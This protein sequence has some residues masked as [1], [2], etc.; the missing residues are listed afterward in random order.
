MTTSLTPEKHSPYHHRNRDSSSNSTS[1]KKSSSA[2]FPF[3][4]V[5]YESGGLLG[6]NKANTSTVCSTNAASPIVAPGTILPPG[7][8]VSTGVPILAPPTSFSTPPNM[9]TISLTSSCGSVEF[10]G[11]T[12]SS[13]SG[14]EGPT[15]EI[16]LSEKVGFGDAGFALPYDHY[17]T[18]QHDQG[19][20]MTSPTAS[21][22]F[23][24]DGSSQVLMKSHVAV[25]EI[26]AR[27]GSRLV[28]VLVAL[29]GLFCAVSGGLCAE[30]HC[31]ELKFCEDGHEAHGNWCGPSG[32]DGAPYMLTVGL[33]MWM[34]GLYA[35]THLRTPTSRLVGYSEIDQFL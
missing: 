9:P 7:T 12:V 24:E 10:P 16:L 6:I 5:S 2:L 18:Y 14:E 29:G 30:H 1:W 17:L 8:I 27:W 15:A 22:H 4:L 31:T 13:A 11:S 35:L 33:S 25:Y 20:T 21:L 19:E 32:V 26:N 23:I 28:M 3:S 34:F